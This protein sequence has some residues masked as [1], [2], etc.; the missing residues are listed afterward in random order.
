MKITICPLF[1]SPFYTYTI[2]LSGETFTLTF[3]WNER[4]EQ[5]LM[6]IED[7]ENDKIAR[8]V[9]L[10]PHYLLIDQLSLVKPVGE[11]VLAPYDST[12]PQI[13]NP[14]ELYKTHYLI[15]GDRGS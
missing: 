13:D 1:D 7:A 9:A 8:G 11:F 15:Y 12:S 6:D 10:V 14:R 2:D 3:R 4:A 5:W